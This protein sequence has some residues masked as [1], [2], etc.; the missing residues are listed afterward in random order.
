MPVTT[1]CGATYSR[2]DGEKDMPHS[3]PLLITDHGK[4]SMKF[5][6]AVIASDSECSFS[7]RG[8]KIIR[9]GSD[10]YLVWQG[11]IQR[12]LGSRN[13]TKISSGRSNL[14]RASIPERSQEGKETCSSILDNILFFIGDLE[15]AS[16][17]AKRNRVL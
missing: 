4:V 7:T 6:I 12:Y 16:C 5:K 13:A 15:V 17:N 2:R 9:E 10:Y 3:M 14:K 11:I 8:L 1:F